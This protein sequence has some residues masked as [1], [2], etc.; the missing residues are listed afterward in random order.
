VHSVG[1]YSNTTQAN[2][3]TVGTAADTFAITVP[4]VGAN[5]T[6][7]QTVLTLPRSAYRSGELKVQMRTADSYQHSD[8]SFVHD[9]NDIYMSVY[10][11]VTSNGELGELSATVSGA[12]IEFKVKQ[13]RPNLDVRIVA[14]ALK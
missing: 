9:D 7:S 5:V 12:N 2:T 1:S 10:G 4:N 3:F 13:N 14:T 8:A 6:T 11:T